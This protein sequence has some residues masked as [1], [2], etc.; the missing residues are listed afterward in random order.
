MSKF[1][2]RPVWQPKTDLHQAR[3]LRLCS[4]DKGKLLQIEWAHYDESAK[5][6]NSWDWQASEYDVSQPLNI[7]VY[8][9]YSKQCFCFIW[10]PDS[11]VETLYRISFRKLEDNQRIAL[12]MMAYFM[13]KSSS[14]AWQYL[15]AERAE[16]GDFKLANREICA[17]AINEEQL[18]GVH[19]HSYAAALLHNIPEV[20][21]QQVFDEESFCLDKIKAQLLAGYANTGVVLE[22]SS[23][24]QQALLSVLAVDLFELKEIV[25]S[26]DEYALAINACLSGNLEPLNNKPFVKSK[27]LNLRANL[28]P[29][30]IVAVCVEA[31]AKS[32]ASIFEAHNFLCDALLLE[33]KLSNRIL[34]QPVIHLSD[35]YRH[36]KVSSV[37]PKMNLAQLEMLTSN[38]NY[39]LDF[40]FASG[41]FDLG[42]KLMHLVEIALLSEQE[43]D[44]ALWRIDGA[45]KNR[46][47]EYTSYL[48]AFKKINQLVNNSVLTFNLKDDG[49][50]ASEVAY[51]ISTLSHYFSSLGEVDES[52]FKTAT[53]EIIH[54]RIHLASSNNEYEIYFQQVSRRFI[55]ESRWLVALYGA[56]SYVEVGSLP[57]ERIKVLYDNADSMKYFFKYKNLD[58]NIFAK[59]ENNLFDYI[60]SNLLLVSNVFEQ[61][62]NFEFPDLL[63]F[64]LNEIKRITQPSAEYQY[65]TELAISV[66]YALGHYVSL[67]VLL[68][69]DL[70]DENFSLAEFLLKYPNI[71]LS[72]VIAEIVP[73]NRS[74]CLENISLL[75]SIAKLFDL[76]LSM[77]I[78]SDR[79]F[80]E[81]MI[82]NYEKIIDQLKLFGGISDNK[83]K[84]FKKIVKCV[85]DK[86]NSNN[87]VE[88]FIGLACLCLHLPARK[89]FL[90]TASY[91]EEKIITALEE[92]ARQELSVGFN[93]KQLAF[94]LL[95][96]DHVVSAQE[97]LELDVE[98]QI[99]IL[100]YGNLL[101]RSAKKHNIILRDFI[102]NIKDLSWAPEMLEFV[103]D[104]ARGIDSIADISKKNFCQMNLLALVSVA[105]LLAV[106]VRHVMQL[107]FALLEVLIINRAEIAK[108]IEQLSEITSEHIEFIK[109][110]SDFADS[111][112]QYSH[113]DQLR[114]VI[115]ALIKINFFQSNHRGA[116]ISAQNI[117]LTMS[118]SPY[119]YLNAQLAKVLSGESTMFEFL[120]NNAGRIHVAGNEY[121]TALDQ[122]SDFLD[123][124]VTNSPKVN[125]S[126][127]FCK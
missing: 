70:Q 119:L 43:F 100:L 110:I 73:G 111:K 85:G 63:Y 4:N 18:P 48:A 89:I 31:E 87:K 84:I 30:S 115:V 81:F 29:T 113:A 17:V 9:F 44:L 88:S 37:K 114:E 53:L 75:F 28:W 124:A 59:L 10:M 112:Q 127:N 34:A 122:I 92:E 47:P 19:S 104:S 58:F 71:R 72:G 99:D 55:E 103:F 90:D 40:I 106:D 94:F 12:N 108:A 123:P 2:L 32:N 51:R 74:Y 69:Q 118:P 16:N 95:A 86:E 36:I 77:L 91:F 23:Q 82:V 1:Y 7:P 68:H 97:F 102:L 117:F 35:K 96:I 98:K 41:L 26:A 101:K 13:K 109:T 61:L 3:W 49:L 67:P 6:L 14:S 20:K 57:I 125:L 79:I 33:L 66:F 93:H 22:L 76:S 60:F 11:K 52:S 78:K 50:L 15:K 5:S 83:F 121:K 105:Q 38:I 25:D 65:N 64:S 80:L 126:I 62:P 24:Q 56:V 45:W 39:A 21:K 42:T 8:D 116:S 120:K 107:N 46:E 54:H 27:A